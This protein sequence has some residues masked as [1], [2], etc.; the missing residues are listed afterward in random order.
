MNEEAKNLV[1]RLSVQH[2]LTVGSSEWEHVA[3]QFEE[4]ERHR[5][6]I[7]GDLVIVRIESG[8]AAVEEPLPK[9]RVIRYLGDM[10]EVRRLVTDRLETYE[11]M[12]DGCGCRIDYYK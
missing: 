2:V 3:D 8:Y 7:K 1:E 12:W 9:E 4:V 11:R 10:D 6:H 5:T